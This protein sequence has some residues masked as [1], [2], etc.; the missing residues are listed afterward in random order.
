MLIIET[1]VLRYSYGKMKLQK[2]MDEVINELN[3]GQ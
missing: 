2:L 3:K 1:K